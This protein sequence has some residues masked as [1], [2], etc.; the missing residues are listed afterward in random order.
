MG[1]LR[2]RIMLYPSRGHPAGPPA[3]RRASQQQESAAAW[4]WSAM[5]PLLLG[6]FSLLLESPGW[7]WRMSFL[8][9]GNSCQEGYIPTQNNSVRLFAWSL[10]VAANAWSRDWESSPICTVSLSQASLMDYI[11]QLPL[12]LDSALG[13]LFSSRKK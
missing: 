2:A 5:S 8:V 7:V 4:D 10:H 6:D 9:S 12:H 13:L 1:T 11:S 3:G